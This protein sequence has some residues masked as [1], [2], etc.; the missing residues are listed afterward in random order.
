MVGQVTEEVRIGAE[1]IALGEATGA[2]AGAQIEFGTWWSRLGGGFVTPSMFW[3]PERVDHSARAEHVPFAFWL[4]DALRPF[5]LVELTETPT[6]PYLAYCQ[7]VSRLHLPT[8]CYAIS[9]D[10]LGRQR[11]AEAEELA[12]YHDD[13]Y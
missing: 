1:Q 12:S 5:A 8:R 6:A 3:P 7:A 2:T 11:T 10:G 4:V 13:R 9:G